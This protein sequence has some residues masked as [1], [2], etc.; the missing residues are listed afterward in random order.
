METTSRTLTARKDSTNLL[1]LRLFTPRS[2]F[3]HLRDHNYGKNIK[4]DELF[5]H[6]R[7]VL[8]AKMKELKQMGK[9]NKPHASHPF[10]DE[11]LKQLSERHLL[12]TSK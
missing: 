3:R 12:G 10:T 8:R 1:L 6:S 5:R 2:I 4:Q 9:G 7:E 11:E